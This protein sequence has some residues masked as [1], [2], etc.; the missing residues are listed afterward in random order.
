M[1]QAIILMQIERGRVDEVAQA[2]LTIDGVFEVYSTAG[3]YDMVALLKV[4]SP[5]RLNEVVNQEM[6]RVDH[7]VRT[8]TL[9]AFRCYDRED[10]GRMFSVGLDPG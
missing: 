4:A 7:I 9:T 6:A 8:H 5:E 2:L 10:L 3:N 1:L